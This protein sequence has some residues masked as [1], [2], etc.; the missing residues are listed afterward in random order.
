MPWLTQATKNKICCIIYES[1][2]SCSFLR[3]LEIPGELGCDM[4]GCK[5]YGGKITYQRMR[6][7]ENSRTPPKR[8]SGLLCRGFL[9][10]KK[11]ALTPE[12]GGKRTVRGGVQNPFVGGVSFVRFSTPLFFHPPMT[13]SERRGESAKICSFLGFPAPSE[14]WKFQEKG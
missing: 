8:A 13:S 14:C 1:A 9:Y 2:F 4:G 3:M 11:R 10:R 6:S 7:P 5:T 12:S